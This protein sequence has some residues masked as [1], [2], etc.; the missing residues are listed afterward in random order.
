MKIVGKGIQKIDGM[1]IATGKP[2][3]TDDLASKEA[4]VVKILRS[5]HAYAKIKNIDTSRAEKVDGVEC[6][7][8]YKDVPNT[9]FTLAGQSYPEPSPYDRLILE[10]TVRYVGDEVAIIAAVD[11]KTAV[12]AMR[13]IKIEYEVLKPVINMEDAIDNEIVVHNQDL[14]CNFD[15]G[16]ERERNIVS[17]HFYEKGNVEEELSKCDFVVEETYYTQAQAHA[18]M[19]TYRAYNY[20]D[21]NGRL[22]VVSSTQI[23][24]HV[25]RHLS[26]ALNIPSSKI[27]VVKP[28]IGGGFGGKQT[29]CVEIF[30]AIVTL[31]TGKPAKIIYD[32]KETFNCSTS[33][34]AMRLNVKIGATKD[35][36]I[37]VIDI[38][39]LSDT[40]AYG[41]HA[42]TTFGLVGEKTMPM[43]NKLKASRFKGNVVYTN[44]MPAGA[45]RGYGATQ[46]CFAV[47]STIN[48]LAHKLNMDP[49]EI[50]LKNI[51]K[52][53]ETSF[54]YNKTLNSVDLAKC[55]DKGKKLINWDEKYPCKK[56]ENGKVRSVGMA[57]T[58]QGSGIAGIDT[59]SAEI[60]LNDDGNYTL[61]IGSTDM[62]TG[63][64]TILSQMACEIL[65][66]NIDK[67]NVISADTDVVPYDPGSYASSTTYVTGMAVVKACNILRDKIIEVGARKLDVDKEYVDFDGE[68]VYCECNKI[69]LFDIAID[70]T[71]GPEKEQLV[72]YA[73]HGSDVSPPPFIAGF[74]ETEM[75]IETGK[76]EVLD[77]VAVVDCGTVINKNLARIQ[78]EGGIVQGIGMAM[79]EEVRYTDDGHMD[80][81]TFMQYKIPARCDV[82]N[83][84]VD[85]VE[86]H[87]PTGPFGAKSVGEVVINTP[88]PAIQEA[89]YNASG[90]RVN[91][92]PITP[93]KVF[94]KMNK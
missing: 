20:L 80:T 71:V 29:A 85:F 8:T 59:A 63:S 28:R 92:L 58:M 41:E 74:V 91:T 15:I 51:V 53:G 26:R 10:D 61:L 68:Y 25:R 79:F 69:S 12:K 52:E 84:V 88:L 75:D 44:K 50:R 21:H 77:Y 19:E 34:H 57:L 62:G 18:M 6:I 73:S 9:R 55:I 87:E 48:I 64:D 35:G 90:V 67:I 49:T 94:M 43:Y 24:F 82:G 89:V 38:D 7:I 47:E 36:V 13:M 32:R 78:V 39:A 42:S 4:L 70:F 23:P 46:G 11:E 37:K 86:T 60:R 2:V 17:K 31:K 93:E 3:Y 83:V 1:A 30:S 56:L 16:M 76:Y 33:R 54:A 45:L 66:T 22:V 65:E 14:H 72:G 27:R 5:P 40:G 81:N